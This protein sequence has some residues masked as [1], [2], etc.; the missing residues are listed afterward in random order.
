MDVF[1][2]MGTEVQF[3]V[4][5]LKDVEKLESC[6]WKTTKMAMMLGLIVLKHK[7]RKQRIKNLFIT[8]TL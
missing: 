8:R 4:R 3:W 6:Q 2:L 5:Q 7:Q 1:I